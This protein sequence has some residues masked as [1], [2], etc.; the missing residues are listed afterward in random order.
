M[1]T[2]HICIYAWPA[3]QITQTCTHSRH[4]KTAQCPHPASLPGWEGWRSASENIYMYACRMQISPASRV[5]QSAPVDAPG[6]RCPQLLAPRGRSPWGYCLSPVAHS[7]IYP[8][9][10]ELAGTSL[11]PLQPTHLVLTLKRHTQVG[12]ILRDLRTLRFLWQLA[13][14]PLILS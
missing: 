12:L 1:H 6:P 11:V 9:R 5:T 8:T 13:G 14:G 4:T 10:A 2:L 3:T 7:C